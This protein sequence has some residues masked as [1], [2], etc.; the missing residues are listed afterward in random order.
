MDD[1]GHPGMDVFPL[2]PS[3]SHPRCRRKNPFPDKS[4]GA[5]EVQRKKGVRG[6]GL[7]SPEVQTWITASVIW[8]GQLGGLVRQPLLLLQ[9]RRAS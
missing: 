5:P 9:L 2:H 7:G 1:L 3:L 6:P 4:C 8:T